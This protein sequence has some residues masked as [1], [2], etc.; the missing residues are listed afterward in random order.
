MRCTGS[1]IIP[2]FLLILNSNSF[3][4]VLPPGRSTDWSMAGYPGNIPFYDTVR[5]IVDFGGNGNGIAVNDAALANAISS[6]NGQAGTVVFPAGTFVF[7]SPVSLRS[8][9]L[10]KGAGA[11]QTVLQFNL[12]GNFN[13]INIL[14]RSTAVT[15]NITAT[16]LRNSYFIAV[17]E[18]SLFSVNDRIRI[19]QNDSSLV[20]DNWALESVG[21]IITI[22]SIHSNN[23]YFH[24]PL[25]RSYTL[26]DAP[27][28][29][30]LDMTE[31]VGIECLKIKR[32]DASAQQTA[33]IYFSNA[34][35]CWVKGLESDSCNFAHIQLA[36]ST[37]IAITN[38]YFHSAFAYGPGGQ[39]YGISCEY[40]SGECLIGNNI[41]RR[42]RH[43][44]LLQ[45]GANGNV[46]AYNYST[47]PFK[48]D[49]IPFDFSGDIVLHGNYPYLNLF[50]GNIVQNIVVDASHGKNG[51]F[52]TFFR[53]RA[54]RYG[55]FIVQNV[56][57]STNIIG[58]EITGTGFQQ[59]NYY[60]LGSGLLQYANNKND[61]IIPP[62][63]GILPTRS[64][65]Y[66]T[67]P[68]FWNS[69]S[70]WGGIGPGN[71]LSSQSIPAKERFIASQEI[72]YCLPSTAVSYRFTGD[73]NWSNAANW[74]NH[75]KP[76][77]VLSNNSEIIIDPAAEQKCMLDIPFVIQ[78]GVNFVVRPSKVFEILAN[79][80]FVK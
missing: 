54:E 66:T 53:N 64:F 45:S 38:N 5:N 21:Q 59:G 19:Y 12:G 39:G 6:L 41:F 28:I 74:D 51:P 68:D 26:A 65:R 20:N 15:S 44:M 32:M 37:N 75:L 46:F 14:G 16:A 11:L 35:N 22:D 58:N 56:G 50:E 3:S 48:T 70:V 62:G 40:S 9:L 24:H 63:T 1:Y 80:T 52:N 27:R 36:S 67:T 43:S 13:C 31:G 2:L 61:T 76:P 49:T 18:P 72:T 17:D 79:L 47:D 10:L 29:R 8:Q 57:D 7:N 30:K 71:S 42:L 60:V 73:G 34:A 78:P 69:S 4:Q 77:L 25:R 23:I 55:L 33:N